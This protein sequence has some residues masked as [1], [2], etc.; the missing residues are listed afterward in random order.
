MKKIL[1]EFESGA[2]GDSIAWIES[3]EQFRKINK[4]D[5][6]VNMERDYLFKNSYPNLIFV[7]TYDK[8]DFD[9]VYTLTWK[10]EPNGRSCSLQNKAANILGIPFD[11]KKFNSKIDY[12]KYP[13]TILIA[14]KGKDRKYLSK[15]INELKMGD[16]VHLI[17]FQNK[18]SQF[19]KSCDFVI[20]PSR[21]EGMP[22]V[23]MESMALGKPV[24]AANVNGVP[25]LI[26][27]EISGYIF[28]PY[29]IDAIRNAMNYV[30][31]NKD[32]SIIKNWGLK[33]QDHV[34]KNF[35]IDIMLDNL[36]SYFYEK[37]N[38]SIR[39]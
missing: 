26:E 13:F 5:V 3:C 28:E 24:L 8:K 23:V 39:K 2:I 1:I 6:S 12:K 34:K 10:D 29:K 18:L 11:S 38:N 31:K 33:A 19:L 9:K 32:S 16:R 37:I 7:D 20:M 15:L 36:E 14:G 17:G 35:T 27:H 30:M 25:E 22:N 21:Q 4:C